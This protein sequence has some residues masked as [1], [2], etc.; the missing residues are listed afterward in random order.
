MTIKEHLESNSIV[1][2]VVSK[3]QYLG[4][5]IEI[6]HELESMMDKVCYVCLTQPESALKEMFRK[7]NIDAGK[8]H[9]VDVL[10]STI[11]QMSNTECCTYV[12]SP[13]A[14]TEISVAFSKITENAK[15]SVIDAISTLLIYE[16]EMAVIRF[17]HNLMTKTRIANLK[18]IFIALH[19]DT[20]T[21]LI[22]DLYMFV[23]KVV[24][25]STVEQRIADIVKNG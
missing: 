22:K 21:N 17:T 5:L 6:L 8:F 18:M 2:V 19:E 15:G 13:S 10:S 20:K 4:K 12:S 16:D 9:F 14:L 3:E 7:N 25:F 1:L 24:D 11:Q 23:D